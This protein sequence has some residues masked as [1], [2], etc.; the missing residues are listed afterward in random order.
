MAAVIDS[1]AQSAFWCLRNYEATDS[2]PCPGNISVCVLA[3]SHSSAKNDGRVIQHL[4]TSL[5]SLF[6]SRLPRVPLEYFLAYETDGAP[7]KWI[8]PGSDRQSTDRNADRLR[9]SPTCVEADFDLNDGEAVTVLIRVEESQKEQL[10]S[11]SLVSLMIIDLTEKVR[12]IRRFVDL[13]ME[14]HRAFPS[15]SQEDP[16]RPV[17]AKAQYMGGV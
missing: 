9:N 15:R 12:R 6:D 16:L 10:P 11:E 5:V 14:L 8:I 13:P 17:T 3:Q 4:K 7:V 1:Y 2:R